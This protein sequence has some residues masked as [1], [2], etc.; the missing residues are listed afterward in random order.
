[1]AGQT[2]VIN[3]PELKLGLAEGLQRESDSS[4][5]LLVGGPCQ[6]SVPDL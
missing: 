2:T 4:G 3:S 1:M 6:D 5:V